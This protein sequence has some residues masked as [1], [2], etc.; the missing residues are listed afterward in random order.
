MISAVLALLIFLAL[1][2]IN[3]FYIRPNRKIRHYARLFE[4]KGFKVFK[5]PFRFLGAPVFNSYDENRFNGDRDAL[6]IVK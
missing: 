1:L 2:G 3:A 5:V 4:A 6:R